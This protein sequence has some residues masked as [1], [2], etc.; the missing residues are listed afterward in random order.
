MSGPLPPSVELAVEVIGTRVCRSANTGLILGSGLAEVATLV[1]S[2]TVI[3]YDEIPG[4]PP[5]SA[6]GHAGRLISGRIGDVRVIV[7]Q[8]RSHLYEG[9]SAQ[10]L[11]LPIHVLRALGV[12]TL[13]LTNASGGLN[14]HFRPGD[15][16]VI[17]DHLVFQRLPLEC[18]LPTNRSLRPARELY[19]EKLAEQA[20]HF[21]QRLGTPVHQG[22]Y[23]AVLGPNY[24]T[25]AEYRMFRKLGADVVG[26][27]TAVE[28][29]AA[30]Q[31]GM[32]TLGLSIVANVARPDAP[33]SITHQQ[34]LQAVES[35]AGHVRQ[36]VEALLPQL[37]AP[38]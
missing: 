19:D 5:T 38:Q 4:F 25:R 20:L 18:A 37:P 1:Q 30:A 21:A 27:S 36:L 17:R 35:A 9:H 2:P 7:L 33:Q 15:V 22:I 3:R 6:A 23:A 16:M 31:R 34:V 13:I 29:L 11:M 32:A 10:A 26:M 24:E 8:G 28:S 14:P 12:R